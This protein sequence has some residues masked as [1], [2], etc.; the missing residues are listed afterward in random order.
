MHETVANVVKQ[1]TNGAAKQEESAEV[2][3]Q[4]TNG[5]TK[6]ES[7]EIINGVTKQEESA[8]P[9]AHAAYI[10]T[11]EKSESAK[12]G[13][14]AGNPINMYK[15]QMSRDAYTATEAHHIPTPKQPQET[16]GI[17]KELNELVGKHATSLND[18]LR[19]GKAVEV[20]EKLG[21][22]GIKDLKSAIGINDQFQFIQDL[23]RSDKVM[24]D[25][26][27]KTINESASLQE[28]EYWIERELKIKLGWNEQEP[29]VQHFLNIVKKRF[30]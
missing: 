6:Q 28:A 13:A 7:A 2:T 29:L 26:S 19:N 8:I 22:M 9:H 24:Y 17:R 3:R 20:G 12:N 11:P 30:S 1:A 18:T 14:S 21:G 10:P 23:F 15:T 16:N 25:R 5:A 4:T 27:V